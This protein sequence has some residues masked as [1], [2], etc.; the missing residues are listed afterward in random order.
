MNPRIRLGIL[1]NELFAPEV[2]RMGG[3]GWAVR[4]VSECF[5]QDPSLG[6]EIRLLMGEWPK[7]GAAIPAALHG[8]PVIWREKR[9]LNYLA[10][11][12]REKLD[13]ILAIDYRPNYRLLF[14]GL[15]Q[16]PVLIWIRDP[17]NRQ[18][19]EYIRT[20]RIPGS[21]DQT[22]QGTTPP[23]CK[24]LSKVLRLSKL[25]HRPLRFAVTSPHLISKMPDCYGLKT[26]AVDVL[27]NIISLQ[28]HKCGKSE[29]PLV[30]FLARLDPTKRPWIFAELARRYPDVQFLFLGQ[31][32]FH[33]PGAWAMASLPSNVRVLG[34]VGEAEKSRLLSSAWVL[35]NTSI[36]E[37]L[38]VSFLEALACET[39]LISSV[40]PDGLVS[41][42]GIHV[43]EWPGTGMESLP[44]FEIALKRLFQNKE[45][46]LRLGR[47]GRD[48]VGSRHTK[49]EFLAA[50]RKI[51]GKLGRKVRRWANSREAWP[52]NKSGV[53]THI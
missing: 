12:R 18:D 21:G 26:K 7:K 24:S 37:G 49:M 17:W 13:A 48:W 33:G 47:E 36:H 52:Q 1:A 2:G 27:P 3:F 38:S 32:H 43:G 20:L 42:F 51:G 46:R 31:Q 40:N 44:A 41:R 45:L 39:P 4:Q 10:Q 23:Q 6:V 9:L 8:A 16:T 11:I 30:V 53:T 25:M 19:I 35:V 22:P 15:P 29:S 28:P 14:F 5:M 50:M 34:H